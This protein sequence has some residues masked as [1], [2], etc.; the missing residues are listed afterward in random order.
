[1]RFIAVWL[2][3]TVTFVYNVPVQLIAFFLPAMYIVYYLAEYKSE[4]MLLDI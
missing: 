1:M 2:Q 3:N 4:V